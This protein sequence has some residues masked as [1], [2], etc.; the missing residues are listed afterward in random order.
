MSTPHSNHDLE[1]TPEAVPDCLSEQAGN[2]E[3]PNW[4]KRVGSMSMFPKPR[5]SASSCYL[6][7]LS[8][9]HFLLSNLTLL[10]SALRITWR[11]SLGGLGYYFFLFIDWLILQRERK[12]ERYQFVVPLTYACF[13]Y[14]PWP[15]IEPTTVVYGNYA[16][17]HWT[18]QPGPQVWHS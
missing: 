16:P 18:N 9:N 11:P 6:R 12:G 15:G 10:P 2:T 1:T 8:F 17:T 14:V 3:T 7:T 13:L 4:R 5:S